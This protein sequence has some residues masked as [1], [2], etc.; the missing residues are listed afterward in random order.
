MGGVRFLS[1]ADGGLLKQLD[2]PTL[3]GVTVASFSAGRPN[4]GVVALGL[5]NGQALVVRHRY[6]VSF[7]DDRRVITPEIEYSLGARTIELLPDGAPLLRIAVREQESFTPVGWS[8]TGLSGI[9]VYDCDCHPQHA[10]DRA[11]FRSQR[12]YVHG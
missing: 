7:P 10:A 8:G 2:L 4:S 12:V 9:Q 5:N 11:R 6:R 1:T 3:A